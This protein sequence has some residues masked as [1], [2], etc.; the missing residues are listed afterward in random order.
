MR[1]RVNYHR[2]CNGVLPSYLT[3][4]GPRSLPSGSS[5]G[6]LELHQITLIT[7]YHKL[8]QRKTK[9]TSADNKDLLHLPWVGLLMNTLVCVLHFLGFG[10]YSLIL[11]EIQVRCF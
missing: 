2:K 3:Y 10:T 11:L 9:N 4:R 1:T 8:F 5:L 6:T 7:G